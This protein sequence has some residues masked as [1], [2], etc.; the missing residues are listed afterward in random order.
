M[1]ANNKDDKL[2]KPSDSVKLQD[3]IP[4]SEVWLFKDKFAL[5]L[6]D[7]GMSEAHN[8]Q[9]IDKGSFAKYINE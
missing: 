3:T 9:L 8:G 5:A 4:A 6:V 2:I 1:P 7:K